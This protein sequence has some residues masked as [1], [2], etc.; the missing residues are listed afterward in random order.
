MSIASKLTDVDNVKTAIADAIEDQGV[1]MTGVAFTDYPDK[2]AEIESVPDLCAEYPA[3]WTAPAG[4]PNIVSIFTAESDTNKRYIVLLKA[5]TDTTVLSSALFPGVATTGGT[6]TFKTSDGST[7][8]ATSQTH[9]WNQSLDID[10]GLG[11]KVRWVM[12]FSTNSLTTQ[13][14]FSIAADTAGYAYVYFGHGRLGS[15][16]AGSP[17]DSSALKTLEAFHV[18]GDATFSSGPSFNME[19]CTNL[20]SLRVYAWAGATP[21]SFTLNCQQCWSLEE[22]MSIPTGLTTGIQLGFSACGRLCSY[23]IPANVGN[24]TGPSGAGPFTG[25]AITELPVSGTTQ[26]QGGS[27]MSQTRVRSV[28]YYQW[29]SA[30]SNYFLDCRELEEVIFDAGVTDIGSSAFSGC[31]NLRKV[32][33]NSGL[34]NISS[35]AFLN[36][37]RLKDITLPSSLLTIGTGA[38][39]GT[40]IRRAVVPSGV[41]HITTSSFPNTCNELIYQGN[42]ATAQVSTVFS[43]YMF[44]IIKFNQLD[45]GLSF[46]ST[47]RILKPILVDLINSL[48]DNSGGGPARTLTL[49]ATALAKMSTAE[50]AP[51]AARNWTLA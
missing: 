7:Y 49:G 24:I 6:T 21:S 17:T 22:V 42:I 30:Y 45:V 35:N 11:Y 28:V 41:T 32:T 13:V 19:Y 31:Q 12:V 25:T 36:C 34:Q 29:M 16:T 20:K 1:S 50:K 44:P 43:T 23:D 2:I 4:W 10:S 39:N 26:L 8:T 27:G 3:T 51:A 37:W 40:G 18:G 15:V 48:K 5:N 14:S 38:F 46:S 9:T 47:N 33:F